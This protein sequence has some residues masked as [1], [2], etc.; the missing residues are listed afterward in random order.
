ML[1]FYPI[2]RHVT[3]GHFFWKEQLTL[4]IHSFIQF[5]QEVGGSLEHGRISK[6]N[7]Y[8]SHDYV[9][10]WQFFLFF[11]STSIAK[12]CVKWQ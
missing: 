6:Q 10:V 1:H 2:E 7:A 5:L 4:F 12:E 9:L 3:I 8:F 11:H